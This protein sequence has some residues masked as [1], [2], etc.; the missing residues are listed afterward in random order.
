[1]RPRS[2]P[3]RASP[4]APLPKSQTAS[5]RRSATRRPTRKEIAAA[6]LRKGPIGPSATASSS[7]SPGGPTLPEHAGDALQQGSRFGPG[8]D[9]LAG[10]GHDRLRLTE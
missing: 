4:R 8:A 9:G 7:A 1:M 10:E 5:G 3:G 2:L 6:S